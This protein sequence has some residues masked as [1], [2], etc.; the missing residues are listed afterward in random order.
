M[1]RVVGVECSRTSRPSIYGHAELQES[2]DISPGPEPTRPDP[3]G[4]QSRSLGVREPGHTRE[5]RDY[6]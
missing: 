5:L 2:A 6:K 3:S 1:E 4:R